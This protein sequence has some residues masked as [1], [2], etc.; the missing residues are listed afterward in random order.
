MSRYLRILV[1]ALALVLLVVGSAL[2]N[3][4]PVAD[5]HRSPVAA[6]Q[7]PSPGASA[8]AN[9][10]KGQNEAD[11]AK[12][13]ADPAPSQEQLDRLVDLLKT[14]GI[15]ATDEQLSALIAKYG[16]GGA[17]RIVAWANGGDTSAIEAL[18]DQ[19]MGWGEIAKQLNGADASLGLK[20]GIGWIMSGGH[21]QGHAA[22]AGAAK[23]KATAP[24]QANKP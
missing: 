5:E 7:Q 8:A 2:A 16:V 18:R 14:A 12:D 20:P 10:E 15:T 9:G 4:S 24:G 1:A 23:G 17:V 19:G 22:Q 6:S 13:A 3:R 11:D 21:G